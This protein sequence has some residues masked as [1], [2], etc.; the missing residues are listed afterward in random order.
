MSLE[1]MVCGVNYTTELIRSN[2]NEL[3]DISQ[4]A[5]YLSTYTVGSSTPLQDAVT[6]MNAV[7]KPLVIDMDIEETNVTSTGYTV[8][9]GN[10]YTI[11]QTNITGEGFSVELKGEDLGNYTSIENITSV[12][13]SITATKVLGSFNVEVGDVVRIVDNSTI[14]SVLN[15]K[16]A[17]MAKVTTVETDHIIL[18]CTLRHFDYY[19]SGRVFKVSKEKVFI[20]DVTMTSG[21]DSVSSPNRTAAMSIKGAISPEVYISIASDYTNG[22]VLKGCYLPIADVKTS[23]L[24]SYGPLA[25]MGCGVVVSGSTKGAVIHSFSTST[26]AA[27]VDT[28]GNSLDD[29]LDFEYGCVLDSLVSGTGY[30]TKGATWDTTPYSDRTTFLNTK[31]SG[32][33]LT[34][35][36]PTDVSLSYNIRGSNVNVVNGLSDRK[37]ALAVRETSKLLLPSDCNV[38]ITEPKV[39]MFGNA[40]LSKILYESNESTHGLN[41]NIVNSLLNGAW[42]SEGTINLNYLK[43]KNT[44]LDLGNGSP[45]TASDKEY[46]IEFEGC[47]LL[48][49]S[50]LRCN[51]KTTFKLINSVLKSSALATYG[52]PIDIY[53]GGNLTLVNC[54]FD[55]ENLAAGIVRG[56]QT[57]TTNTKIY[58]SGLYSLSEEFNNITLGNGIALADIK[59]TGVNLTP[60]S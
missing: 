37:F 12:D 56:V 26:R 38:Q 7:K 21:D 32:V 11:T 52:S 49:V 36:D 8:I 55:G 59:D 22:L 6:A 34:D 54:G 45:N 53:E 42:F 25:L 60:A 16:H 15:T 29:T 18:D 10:G 39:T 1:K 27:Y 33:V 19:S 2:L 40:S 43:F 58:A 31:S 57:L 13:T 48:N 20:E 30:A 23:D 28:I 44:T 50:T 51:S 35:L 9:K 41:V 4:G 3:I 5:L 17:E 46:N 47:Q 24:K 14:D